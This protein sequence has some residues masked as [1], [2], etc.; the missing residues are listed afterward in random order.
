METARSWRTYAKVEKSEADL[1]RLEKRLTAIGDGDHF[2]TAGGG[3]AGSAVPRCDKAQATFQAATLA[4]DENNGI[5][6]SNSRIVN[7]P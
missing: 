4:V 6:C 2:E 7:V 3:E 5:S 1:E